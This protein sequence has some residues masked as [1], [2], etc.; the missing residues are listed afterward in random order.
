MGQ[1]LSIHEEFLKG[2]QKSLKIRG[3]VIKREDL[4]SFFN[5]I[6]EICPWFPQE[7]R[8]DEKRWVRV[9]DAIQDRYRMCSSKTVPE[10]EP[11]FWTLIN[12]VLSARVWHPDAEAT[13]KACEEYLKAESKRGSVKGSEKG[14]PSWSPPEDES[15]SETDSEG[16]EALQTKPEAPSLSSGPPPYNSSLFPNPPRATAPR[17]A[18]TSD[19]RLDSLA[20]AVQKLCDR[21]SQLFT[22][23]PLP[24]QPRFQ[25]QLLGS[26]PE[27]ED[28]T[29]STRPTPAA[30]HCPRT[31]QAAPQNPS[32]DTIEEEPQPP[33]HPTEL[34]NPY[35]RPIWRQLM[36]YEASNRKDLHE[37]FKAVNTYGPM[38]P[39][40][41]SCLESMGGDGI[42][43]PLEWHDIVRTALKAHLYLLWERDFLHRCKDLAGDDND[44]FAQISGSDP[45][46]R[47]SEQR[48]LPRILLTNTA[49]AAMRAWKSLPREGTFMAPLAQIFQG[50][51]EPY[52]DFIS[53]LLEAIERVL[54]VPTT[55]TDNILVKHL[56]FENANSTCRFILRGN[57]KGKTLHDMINMCREADPLAHKIAIAVVAFQG[58]NK[59][60]T[61]F[62]C[63]VPGHFA[64]RCPQRQASAR[65]SL[66][67]R[68]YRGRHWASACRSVYDI[69]GTPLPPVQGNGAWAPQQTASQPA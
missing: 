6:Q 53:R 37:L 45:Y 21:I 23:S 28:P 35:D 63:G 30:T 56:A 29:P 26:E 33:S 51:D 57:L 9:R 55:D 58:Q 11:I 48:K 10:I 5:Y 40:T 34:A 39:Y 25:F 8:I 32:P 17:G 62:Q 65:P 2:I 36:E 49:M 69:Q 38:A 27:G 44:L 1:E 7:G 50:P 14:P 41:L 43:L 61:C 46:S 66:C 18:P 24:S 60:K 19:T 59:R 3:V 68:C 42:V 52:K 64:S 47:L 15:E 16:E 67:P 31:R 4:V 12:Y 20:E 13:V 22:H 54:G